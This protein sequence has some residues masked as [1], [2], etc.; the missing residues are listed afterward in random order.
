MAENYVGPIVKGCL[1]VLLLVA[2]TVAALWRWV[3]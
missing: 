1:T 2:A 3:F